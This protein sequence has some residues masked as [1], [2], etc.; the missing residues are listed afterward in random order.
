MAYKMLLLLLLACH[1][2]AFT[3]AGIQDVVFTVAGMP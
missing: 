3:V 1:D 2:V